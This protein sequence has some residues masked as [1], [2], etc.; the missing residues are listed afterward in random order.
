MRVP[1]IRCSNMSNAA[2]ESPHRA[3]RVNMNTDSRCQKQC[4]SSDACTKGITGKY[5]R[6]CE[7]T[8]KS[9]LTSG[10][11]TGTVTPWGG[12]GCPSPAL[13]A[14]LHWPH[15]PSLEP[16]CGVHSPCLRYYEETG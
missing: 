8:T 2:T 16:T 9:V 1:S 14:Q 12:P 7:L 4:M 15:A 5:W 6:M 13:S 11:V 3:E 10:T